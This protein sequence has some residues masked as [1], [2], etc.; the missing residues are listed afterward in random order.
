MSHFAHLTTAELEG[1][2]HTIMQSPADHGVVD[3]IVIRPSV[4]ERA[5]PKQV[6]LDPNTGVAGDNWLARG[7]SKTQSDASTERQVTIMNSRVV[8]LVAQTADRWA[9][10]GDQFFVDMDLGEQNL[11]AG[12][13]LK[14]GTAELEVTR[15]PHLGCKK[16]VERFGLDAMKFV[17]S[18]K[19]KS[20]RLRGV[21]ARIIRAGQVACGDQLSKL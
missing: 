12:S 20:L 16:F 3:L 4:N 10:A 11:P 13:R 6:D 1:G 19:G 17:N 8:S 15:E 2:L 9:L 18:G 21:N 5:L 14:I 7:D